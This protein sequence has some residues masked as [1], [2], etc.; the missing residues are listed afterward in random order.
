MRDQL[1]LCTFRAAGPRTPSEQ[2]SA[3][4]PVSAW[5]QTALS[6]IRSLRFSPL[7]QIRSASPSSTPRSSEFPPPPQSLSDQTLTLLPKT[8]FL[9]DARQRVEELAVQYTK[10]DPQQP[11]PDDIDTAAYGLVSSVILQTAAENFMNEKYEQP[12]RWR[13]RHKLGSI[14]TNITTLDEFNDEA[15]F[16]VTP[17]AKH[18]VK[19]HPV[20]MKTFMLEQPHWVP[21]NRERDVF[22][23]F[24]TEACVLAIIQPDILPKIVD[25]GTLQINVDDVQDP[26]SQASLRVSIESSYTGKRE[27]LVGFIIM[28]RLDEIPRNKVD[29]KKVEKAIR[30]LHEAG[31]VHRDLNKGNVMTGPGGQYMLI[32]AEHAVI[33][34]NMHKNL[35]NTIGQLVTVEQQRFQEFAKEELESM[36]DK[37]RTEPPSS[38]F[39]DGGVLTPQLPGRIRS[40]FETPSGQEDIFQRPDTTPRGVTPRGVTPRGVHL[41]AGMQ[42]PNVRP[43]ASSSSL[44]GVESPDDIVV[45]PGTTPT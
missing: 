40:A 37:S 14:G 21:T 39:V 32:D 30:K 19:H 5:L 22:K 8:L 35:P 1:I 6:P 38:P 20:V 24:L 31:I 16:A 42:T 43:G 7:S 3:L 11:K 44:Q 36:E 17:E 29:F 41:D 25:F 27:F 34:R 26:Q 15:D 10:L 23:G 18:I 45:R 4:S 33:D 13:F 9:D 28:Q 2:K 12:G